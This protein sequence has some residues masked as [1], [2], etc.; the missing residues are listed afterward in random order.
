VSQYPR[1]VLTGLYVPNGSPNYPG[2]PP[3]LVYIRAGTVL[4]CKP[5]S[6]LEGL[7]GGPGNLSPV[8]PVSQR[9]QGETLSHEALSNLGGPDM[10]QSIYVFN[11]QT[12]QSTGFVGPGLATGVDDTEAQALIAAGY[13]A[14]TGWQGDD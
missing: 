7:Y 10:A 12:V 2:S 14:G 8:I 4:D 13:A 11:G 1:R 3:N 9:G 6:A 5:G